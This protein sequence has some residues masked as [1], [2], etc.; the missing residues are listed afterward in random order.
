M[1]DPI[2]DFDP[3]QMPEFGRQQYNA[4][5]SPAVMHFGD[6]DVSYASFCSGQ[7]LNE[8]FIFFRDSF[9]FKR[10]VRANNRNVSPRFYN[11]S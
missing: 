3:L 11:F 7:F 5:K 4:M 2:L 10:R 9:A 6:N 1:R 8:N